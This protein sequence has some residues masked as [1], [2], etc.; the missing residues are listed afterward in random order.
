[1]RGLRQAIGA[2]VGVIL[3]ETENV[4]RWAGKALEVL[5]ALAGGHQKCGGEGAENGVRCVCQAFEQ[6]TE[7]RKVAGDDWRMR[8]GIICEL[9]ESVPWELDYRRFVSD[10]SPEIAP[11]EVYVIPP[12]SQ[13]RHFS[14]P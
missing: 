14:R 4:G 7:S 1:M 6:A 5:K 12:S 3:E 13:S 9:Q 11:K 10:Q 2:G 8:K